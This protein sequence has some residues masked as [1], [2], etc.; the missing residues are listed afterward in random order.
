M[1]GDAEEAE[2][3]EVSTH[4]SVRR[5]HVQRVNLRG[6]RAVSTHASVRRRPM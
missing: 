2:D 1:R 6:D 3:V 4:A 5:R